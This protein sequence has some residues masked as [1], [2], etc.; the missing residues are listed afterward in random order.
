[1]IITKEQERRFKVTMN[2][3]ICDKKLGKD[4]V[5]DRCHITDLYRGPAHNDC[6]LKY[7]YKNFKI[8]VFFH[9]LKVTIRT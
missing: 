5:R 7:N 9:N 1:M 4:R 8:P 3:H 6:N 2:C